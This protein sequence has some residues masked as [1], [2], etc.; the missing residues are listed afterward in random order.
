MS[1]TPETISV[2]ETAKLMNASVRHVREW[3]RRGELASIKGPGNRRL[4]L[5]SAIGAL[6]SNPRP[7]N[8][9]LP[10]LHERYVHGLRVPM[11]LT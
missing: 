11:V 3:I 1:D 8:R 7:S 10:S 6:R 2:K 4:I 5:R 9:K